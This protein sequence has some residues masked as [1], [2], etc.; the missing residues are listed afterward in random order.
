M[1][2]RS[3]KILCTLG[4]N[5]LRKDF[6]NF[7]KGKISL[8]RLNISHIE[9]NKLKKI[10]KF[11]KKNSKI[12]ICIDTEGAQVRT[13]VK[14][15]TYY[16][17]NQIFKLNSNNGGNFNLYPKNVF[18]NLKRNDLLKIGFN[19]LKA[20]VFKVREKYILLKVISSGLLE[21][22]KGVT[23][24]NRKIKLDYLTEKDFQAIKIKHLFFPNLYLYKKLLRLRHKMLILF[25][26]LISIR[27]QRPLIS[28][29]HSN[30]TKFS[31]TRKC[32]I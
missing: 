17:N 16:K 12:P 26:Y 1:S 9:I 3:I 8:L 7:A 13:K 29:N 32:R 11:I 14:K 22:N 24:H 19:E 5:T 6:L 27:N 25:C 31:R 30:P 23:L 20:K 21:N 18:K 28:I 15:T 10:I 4:P 2:T